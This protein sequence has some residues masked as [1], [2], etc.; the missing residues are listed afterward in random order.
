M[1][2][3]RIESGLVKASI[4]EVDA[5]GGF[6]A[7]VE[8]VAVEKMETFRADPLTERWEVN[9]EVPRSVEAGGRLLE[10]RLGSRVLARMGIEVVW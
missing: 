3:T 6:S 4:E 2:A 8:G 7:T 9:F 1:S 10:I 5:I